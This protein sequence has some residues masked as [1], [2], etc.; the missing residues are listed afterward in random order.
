MICVRDANIVLFIGYVCLPQTAS[1]TSNIREEL[2]RLKEILAAGAKSVSADGT[3]VDYDL[4]YIRK[5]V[6][7]L[8]RQIDQ[9][10]RPRLIALDLRKAW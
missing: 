1:M 10:K 2:D 8:Q 3:R 6:E 7:E 4:A 5:R 9:R